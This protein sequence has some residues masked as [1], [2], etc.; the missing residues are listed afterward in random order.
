MTAAYVRIREITTI[1]MIAFQE[2]PRQIGTF[3]KTPQHV[4][5]TEFFMQVLQP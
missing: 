3:K 4:G 5:G 1:Y 2:K